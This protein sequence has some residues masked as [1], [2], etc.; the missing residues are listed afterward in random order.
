MRRARTARNSQ[1][2]TAAL[3]TMIVMSFLFTLI[4]GFVHICMFVVTKSMTNYAAF[5]ASRA[6]LVGG[7]RDLAARHVMS[8]IQWWDG[9][10]IANQARMLVQANQQGPR[11]AGGRRRSGGVRVSYLLPFGYPVFR[12]GLGLVRAIGFATTSTPHTSV[13]EEGDNK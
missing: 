10:V 5:A 3:E 11:L 12:G 4:F 8:E 2:G 6:M 7:S 1:A 9:G 13:P